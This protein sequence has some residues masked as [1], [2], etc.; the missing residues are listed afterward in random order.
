MRALQRGRDLRRQN[1]RSASSAPHQLSKKLPRSSLPVGLDSPVAADATAAV[2][3]TAPTAA[4]AGAAEA[5]GTGAGAAPI[6]SSSMRVISATSM[7]TRPCERSSTREGTSRMRGTARRMLDAVVSLGSRCVFALDG[8]DD[9]LL[10]TR[11]LG[12]QLGHL[13]GGHGHAGTPAV[14]CGLCYIAG[15]AQ[16]WDNVAASSGR[17]IGNEAR[18]KKSAENRVPVDK[19]PPSAAPGACR[20]SPF[21]RPCVCAPISRLWRC[22]FR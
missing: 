2:A 20:P 4:A 7:G 8:V 13:F 16:G 12:Q 21:R 22:L 1:K 9:R 18:P 19:P 15:R 5:A 10:R 3:A 17:S 6:A 11:N 14:G